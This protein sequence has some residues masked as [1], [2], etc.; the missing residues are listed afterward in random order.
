[1][2]SER[3]ILRDGF[4][5]GRLYGVDI[6]LHLILVIIL[7]LRFLDAALKDPPEG[8]VF[9]ISPVLG[10]F[11]FAISLTLSIL[12]HEFGHA[13]AARRAGGDCRR[14]MLWPLGGLAYCD[15]PRTHENRFRVAIAGPVVNIGL[16]LIGLIVCLVA[17]WPVIPY[18]GEVQFFSLLFQFL[19]LWNLVLTIV[20][21]LPCWPL[22]GGNVLHAKI[23]KRTGSEPGSLW[24]TLNISRV[25][26]IIMLVL[27]G[28][29][30]IMA[31]TRENWR[32]DHPVL[33]A[34][35]LI[36][37]LGGIMHFME[38]KMARMQLMH[39]EMEEE[40]GIFG[41]DFSQGYTSL[42]GG[43]GG[44][45]G[46]GGWG[47]GGG[48]G[49]RKPSFFEKRRAEKE[50]KEQDRRVQEEH[51][52]RRRLDELLE[53]ISSEGMGSLSKEERKF[54]DRASAQMR[55]SEAGRE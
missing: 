3:S 32:H 26:A 4:R 22:D 47:G 18:E 14:I 16:G 25:T 15:Y 20:N 5:L 9:K 44:G 29:L 39:G 19:F 24:T 11:A 41:Y 10:F 51:E 40:G 7:A 55:E 1:M 6:H 17:G 34:F 46:G 31:F 37:L 54:L 52:M 23:W 36:F 53:K 8:F 12:L 30:L 13:I 49:E 42:E 27:G 43:A 35:S 21:L 2:H 38:A 45:A 33:D 28:I 50:R 48:T